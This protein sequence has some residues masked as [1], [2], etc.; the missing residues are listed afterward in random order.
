MNNGT[1]GIIGLLTPYRFFSDF[2]FFWGD[3]KQM[4]KMR[5]FFFSEEVTETCF[6]HDVYHL[7]GLRVW[8]G[9]V[10]EAEALLSPSSPYVTSQALTPA[11]ERHHS[12]EGYMCQGLNS[13][14]WGWSSNFY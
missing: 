14:C 9:P 2:L 6:Q 5:C 12:F 1:M 3:T 13:L 7:Y 11:Y 4:V 8:K 10:H